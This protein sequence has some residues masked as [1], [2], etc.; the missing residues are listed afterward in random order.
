MANKQSGNLFLALVIFI[1]IGYSTIFVYNAYNYDRESVAV[2]GPEPECYQMNVNI[3]GKGVT[4]SCA[5]QIDFYLMDKSGQASG[6]PVTSMD[7]GY[8]SNQKQV[9]VPNM[10]KKIVVRTRDIEKE[11]IF[12]SENQDFVP[13]DIPNPVTST[14]GTVTGAVTGTIPVSHTVG[15]L[16]YTSSYSTD[17]EVHLRLEGDISLVSNTQYPTR[18]INL[19]EFRK[20]KGDLLARCVDVESKEFQVYQGELDGNYSPPDQQPVINLFCLFD[21]DNIQFVTWVDEVNIAK[22]GCVKN[23]KWEVFMNDYPA[24]FDLPI[25]SDCSSGYAD[26]KVDKGIWF[27]WWIRCGLNTQFEWL[28]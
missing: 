9:T 21:K 3:N 4:I 14:T 6:T 7:T 2:A 28:G 19:T 5:E 11:N 24:D 8:Y 10:T 25:M 13:V 22:K 26:I 15:G 20:Q 12:F 18:Y 17:E 27:G 1:F 23:A 16:F